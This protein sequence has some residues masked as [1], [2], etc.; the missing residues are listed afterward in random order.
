MKFALVLNLSAFFFGNYFYK[1]PHGFLNVTHLL[2]HVMAS[3]YAAIFI[4]LLS[5]RRRVSGSQE[6]MRKPSEVDRTSGQLAGLRKLAGS[7]KVIHLLL[8]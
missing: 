6:S 1:L 5:L 7:K 8:A 3:Y 4:L 2:R